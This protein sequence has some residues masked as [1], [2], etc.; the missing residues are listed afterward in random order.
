[1]PQRRRR[2]RR[3]EPNYHPNQTR[4]RIEK[5]SSTGVAWPEPNRIE[6]RLD[7]TE[8]NA[9]AVAQRFSFGLAPHRPTQQQTTTTTRKHRGNTIVIYRRHW[10]FLC[11]FSCSF[12]QLV[13]VP[14]ESELAGFQVEQPRNQSRIR[15]RSNRHK[16]NNHQRESM[17][18]KERKERGGYG[19]ECAHE[20]V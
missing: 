18:Y 10:L 1:M 15:I 17:C 4:S 3:G 2:R 9:I 16:P 19:G 8:W 20:C 11:P 13:R 7:S 5:T 14:S 12:V 6:S